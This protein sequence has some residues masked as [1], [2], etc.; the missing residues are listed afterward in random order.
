MLFYQYENGYLYNS[1]SIFLYD[2]ASAFVSR[3]EI[4]DIGC[5]CGIISLLLKRDNP[6]LNLYMID[7]QK[8]MVELANINARVNKIEANILFDSF[9]DYNFLDLKFDA[10]ISNPPFWSKESIQT[11]NEIIRVA[12][13]EDNLYFEDLIKKAKKILKP[14]GDL[15]FCYDAKKFSSCMVALE[16]TGLNPIEIRFL[17]PKID[18]VATIFF[19]R[20]RQN[21]KS[22]DKILPPFVSFW[23]DD[24]SEE[25]KD[26]FKRANTHSIKYNI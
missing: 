11:K 13:Y 14:K 12:R 6:T 20:A 3:G 21:S 5:G 9:E 26:I 18:R 16:S 10:I 25:A 8:E 2:F 15:I 23:G 19:C 1:D 24:Y 17:H 4:L 22:S 7:R